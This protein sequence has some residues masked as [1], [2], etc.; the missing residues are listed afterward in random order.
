MRETWHTKVYSWHSQFKNGYEFVHNNKWSGRPS[1]AVMEDNIREVV[2]I[3]RFDLRLTPLQKRQ[4]F[5]IGVWGNCDRHT[6]TS[7]DFQDVTDY[8]NRSRIKFNFAIYSILSSNFTPS[9]F[10]SRSSCTCICLRKKD[11]SK[12]HCQF[13]MFLMH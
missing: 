1:I 11:I 13:Q 4:W 3:L 2:E 12:L 9:V 8:Y 10:I 7:K 6:A 5:C